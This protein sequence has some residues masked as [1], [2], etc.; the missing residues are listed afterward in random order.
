LSPN[1]MLGCSGG[2]IVGAAREFERTAALSIT[3]AVLPDVIVTPF[4][5]D[6]ESL[7]GPDD[8]PRRWEAVAGV[9]AADSPNFV[10]LA[11]PFTM[12]RAEDLL[13]GF[14]FAF[15]QS[16]KIGGLASG[17]NGPGKNALFLAH[18]AHAEVA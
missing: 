17:A 18:A 6:A 14:D 4:H 12:T 7:P 8:P 1:H 16:V 15:P 3:A 10:V 9:H 2:G 13:R 5:L 11:D